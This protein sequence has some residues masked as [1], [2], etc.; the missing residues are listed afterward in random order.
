MTTMTILGRFLEYSVP[1]PDIA[2]SASFYHQLGFTALATGDIR[3]HHYAVFTDG[4]IAIG[5]HGSGLAEPA[6]TFVLPGLAAR[7]RALEALGFEIE[8]AR[9]GSEEFHELGV[10]GPAGELL[11]VI[12]ARTFSP[13]LGGE[14]PA[15]VLGRLEAIGVGAKDRRAAA[16]FWEGAGLVPDDDE[17]LRLVAPGLR[18]ALDEARG[19]RFRGADAAALGAVAERTGLEPRPTETGIELETPEGLRLHARP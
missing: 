6:L 15:P 19:L 1:A 17:G 2:A 4:R 11:L 8:F 13:G 16:A 5:L 9:L 10:R 18:L 3:A 12:E 14:V 7:A